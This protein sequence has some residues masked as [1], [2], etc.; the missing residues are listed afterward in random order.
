MCGCGRTDDEG[1]RRALRIESAKTG[2]ALIAARGD[3]IH[4]IPFDAPESYVRAPYRSPIVSFGKGGTMTSWWYRQ[5]F[6]DPLGQLVITEN[7]Q[8]IS[9]AV[10]PRLSNFRPVALTEVGKRVAFFSTSPQT[11]RLY[12]ASFDLSKSS[13]V[14]ELTG[15]PDWSPDGLSLVYEKK[16]QIYTVNVL[17]SSAHA[18]AFGRD[19]TWSPNGKWIS[20]VG[21]DG[22][23]SLMTTDGKSAT[24]ALAKYKPAGPIRW[25]PDG[26]YVSF[27]EKLPVVY[28]LLDAVAR[29]L[30]C[31]PA[32]GAAI[33][34]RELNSE[35]ADSRSYFWIVNY[36]RFCNRCPLQ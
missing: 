7:G 16:G 13:P 24:W 12:W 23:A 4:V 20:F 29:L 11:N 6:L 34:I 9:T 30:V 21:T 25:S 2:L 3:Q 1:L 28:G 27:A 15:E 32:D 10:S 19:P 8:T 5:D 31:R 22:T 33:G 36:H 26:S 17:T 14:D 35:S 18:L